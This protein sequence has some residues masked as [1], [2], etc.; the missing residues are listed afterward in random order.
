[1]N[2]L[3]QINSEQV[4]AYSE[5]ISKIWDKGKGNDDL[6]AQTMRVMLESPDIS[7]KLLS[8]FFYFNP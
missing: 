7:Q 3:Y 2:E 1:M 5:F 8:A 4:E 6:S